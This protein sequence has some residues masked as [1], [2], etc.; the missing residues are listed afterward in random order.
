VCVCACE[1]EMGISYTHIDSI[2]AF[3]LCTFTK[4]YP[5]PPIKEGI[6]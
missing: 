5:L 4:H 2:S 1:R 3:Y 6:I